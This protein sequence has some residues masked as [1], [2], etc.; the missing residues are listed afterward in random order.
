MFFELDLRKFVLDQCKLNMHRCGANKKCEYRRYSDWAFAMDN[1]ICVCTG[2]FYVDNEENGFPAPLMLAKLQTP[3]ADYISPRFHCRPCPPGCGRCGSD[4]V[5]QVQLDF[6]LLRAISLGLQSFCITICLILGVAL[7]RLRRTRVIKAANWVLMEILLIGAVLLYLIVVAMYFPASDLTC[8]LVPWLR[9]LGFSIMYGVLIVKIYRV[10]SAFQ[11]RKAHRVHVRNKDILKFLSIFIITTFTY[12]VAWTAVNL[13][14]I[15]SAPW[16]RDP[17]SNTPVSIVQQ[18]YISVSRTLTD[19]SVGAQNASGTV[20]QS[21]IVTSEV[22]KRTRMQLMRFDVCR[23]MSWDVVAE[24]AEFTILAVSIHYCRL[25]RTAPSEYNETLY[26]TIALIIELT[27]SGIL[28]IVRHAIWYSVHPDYVFLLYFIRSHTTITVNLALIFGPKAWFLYRPPNTIANIARSRGQTAAPYSA[29][30]NL[31][32]TGKLN[33]ALNGDLD[34]ADINLAD[35]NPEVIRRELKRLYTQIELYKTKAMRKDNPHISKRRGGRKQR[36]FSLQPFHKRHHGP[37]GTGSIPMATTDSTYCWA[38][39]RNKHEN[40][41]PGSEV[42]PKHGRH[43]S[44]LSTAPGSITPGGHA[45]NCYAYSSIVH[46]EEASKFSEE[47]TNSGDNLS[48]PAK[49]N[50]PQQALCVMVPYTNAGRTSLSTT[51]KY[52]VTASGSPESDCTL[53]ARGSRQ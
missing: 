34:I 43:G 35:M 8:L 20:N 14:Y 28:N 5:C 11:S 38:Q 19:S 29:D 37:S 42:C 50:S 6:N 17:S 21:E 15:S 51:A 13:D 25:V 9:E 4:S 41:G 36:R 12:M 18:G 1:Y 26:I 40:M 52:S 46:D 30:P 47:S 45:G 2:S 16:N 24:L 49:V 44:S 3:T 31:A 27:V 39:Y 10:L 48:P 32:S 23:A 53:H 7:L 22:S 33:L